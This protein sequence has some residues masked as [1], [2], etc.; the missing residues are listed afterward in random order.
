MMMSPWLSA[1]EAAGVLRVNRATLYAYVSRGFVRSQSMPGSTRERGYSREDVDRLRRR[2]EERRDPDKA[3]ARALQW[4]VPVLESAITLID[5]QRI[6]YRGHDA[7]ALARSRT[8]QEVASLVWAGRFD[9]SFSGAP[10]AGR[11]AFRFAPDLPFTA[12]AQSMLAATAAHDPVAFDLRA[13][14]AAQCG[15]RIVELLTEAATGNRP[16]TPRVEEP[17][18]RAWG[19]RGR[20]VDVLRAVLILCADHELNVSSF[21]ARCVASAGAHPYGVV[22][23]GLAALEGPKHGGASARV[24]SMLASMRRAPHVG[25]A[26]TARLRRGEPLDGFGHPLYRQ[27]D[28]RAA[29]I[30]GLLREHY[31]R[32][33]EVEFVVAVAAAAA[34]TV[35]EQANLDFALASAAR[36]LRLPAGAPLTLFAIGRTIGWIGHAIEQYA[37]GQLIRPRAKYV[38]PVPITR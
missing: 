3:V 10:A 38:G 15:W 35:R 11:A 13:E 30:L 36:V 6:Y 8:V 34:S 12:R 19:V 26:V 20:G 37:T 16:D 4:G 27:G 23:A 31:A 14:A 18:A 22:I 9:I 17:L 1:T 21:T 5:G 29:A 28:P 7:L 33:P 25:R 2:T 24:E 32:S